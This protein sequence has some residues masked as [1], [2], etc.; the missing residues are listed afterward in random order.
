MEGGWAAP[1]NDGYGYAVSGMRFC[2]F[3]GK[4]LPG[5]PAGDVEGQ[6][7]DD[8]YVYTCCMAEHLGKLCVLFGVKVN[9]DGSKH[10]IIG[11]TQ[12][13]PVDEVVTWSRR[14]SAGTVTGIS[15]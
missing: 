3:C 2:P 5:V 10:A 12:V 8:Q 11:F 1:E 14:K 6:G 7:V 9:D 4:G 13:V 15:G